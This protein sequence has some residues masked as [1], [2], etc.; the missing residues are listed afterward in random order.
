MIRPLENE[1]LID[2]QYHSMNLGGLGRGSNSRQAEE[3]SLYL[4]PELREMTILLTI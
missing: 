3:K 1:P 4:S 2:N